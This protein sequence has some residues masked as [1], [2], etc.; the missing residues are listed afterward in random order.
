MSKMNSNK[1]DYTNAIQNLLY[2]LLSYNYINKDKV[3]ILVLGYSDITEKF[4]D[5][6]FEMAPVSSW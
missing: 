2:K 4:I 6:A 1:R 5:F 3:N